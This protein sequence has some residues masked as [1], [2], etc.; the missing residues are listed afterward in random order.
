MMFLFRI[1]FIKVLSFEMPL[2]FIRAQDNG[3]KFVRIN[4]LDF[5]VFII[6]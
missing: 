2:I 5:P 4:L 3:R 6:S 1:E